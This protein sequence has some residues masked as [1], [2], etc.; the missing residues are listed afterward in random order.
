MHWECVGIVVVI[1]FIAGTGAGDEAGA[2]T[3]VGV[4]VVSVQL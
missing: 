4:V 1:T 2:G 3:E